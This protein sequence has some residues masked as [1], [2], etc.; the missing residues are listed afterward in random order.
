MKIKLNME[1]KYYILVKAVLFL[2][3]FSLLHYLYDWFPN[4][5][6]A[7]F[8][9]TSES[10]YQHMKI[11]F[12]VYMII[13]L[14]EYI[15]FRN[16]IQDKQNFLFSRLLSTF[17]VPYMSMFFYLIGSMFGHITIVF[18]E[19]I[20]SISICFISIFPVLILEKWYGEFDYSFHTKIVI[21][22]LIVI[23]IIEFTIFTFNL[24][25]H[26]IFAIPPGY[27]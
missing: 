19:V 2:L 15:I 18:L 22:I 10:I 4:L 12:Y 9:G 21:V 3:L 13:T 6:I 1:Y 27:E 26:D 11:G 25:W 5:I 8:S 23:S 17:L 16:Q 14:I 20:Y 24:P 7:L